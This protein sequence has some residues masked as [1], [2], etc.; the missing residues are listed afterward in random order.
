MRQG[1]VPFGENL[2]YHVEFVP[3]GRLSW[4]QGRFEL[5][6]LV[7]VKTVNA[8]HIDA[9]IDVKS[10][11]TFDSQLPVQQLNML[12]KHNTLGLTFPYVRSYLSALTALSGLTTVTLPTFNLTS[13]ADTL[14]RNIVEVEVL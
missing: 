6:L 8:K 13:L 7:I 1:S 14:A 12:F 4:G 11:F 5:E 2:S 3:K 10:Y 9:E